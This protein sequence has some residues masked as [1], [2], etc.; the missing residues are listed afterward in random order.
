MFDYG[1]PYLNSK[2]YDGKESPPMYPIERITDFPIALIY[3][4]SDTL[5]APADCF[6]LKL[7]LE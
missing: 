6:K 4:K 2:K 3:G 1:T 5:A 7:L